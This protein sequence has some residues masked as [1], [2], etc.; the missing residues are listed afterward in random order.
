[1]VG[2]RLPT[3]VLGGLTKPIDWFTGDILLDS[4][5]LDLL[6]SGLTRLFLYLFIIIIIF[7]FF[8]FH[9]VL[10]SFFSLLIF[11]FFPG[12]M[13]QVIQQLH[14]GGHYLNGLTKLRTIWVLIISHL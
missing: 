2:S 9:F 10:S 6:E 5:D 8:F 3:W 12:P 1:M 7:F 4:D 13:I 14:K 11:F